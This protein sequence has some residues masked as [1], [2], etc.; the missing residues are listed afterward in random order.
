MNQDSFN[1]YGKIGTNIW[2]SG[3][4]IMQSLPIKMHKVE[5]GIGYKVLTRTEET[6]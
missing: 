6:H 1:I 5:V 3:S 4:A 2:S